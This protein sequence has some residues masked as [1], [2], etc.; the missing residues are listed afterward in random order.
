MT[1]V[2]SGTNGGGKKFGSGT[3]D[4]DGF[5]SGTGSGGNG[6]PRI[7]HV[8]TDIEPRVRMVETAVAT[9]QGQIP[10]LA[11]KQDVE[12]RPSRSEFW[13]GIGIIGVAICIAVAIVVAVAS[14]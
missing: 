12:T 14:I 10:G 6:P 1:R 5:Q 2:G 13:S 3:N 4:G 8:T 7:I 11:T 9:I